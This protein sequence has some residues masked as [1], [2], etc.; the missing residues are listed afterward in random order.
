MLTRRTRIM[1]SKPP[2][3]SPMTARLLCLATIAALAGV[4]T[5][6]QESYDSPSGEVRITGEHFKRVVRVGDKS[7]PLDSVY[8]YASLR[9]KVGNL[10]LVSA[11]SGGNACA[12]D[13]RWLDTTPGKVAMSQSFG[14]CSDL[15]DVSNTPEVVTVTMPSMN[16]S[17]GKIAFDFDGKTISKRMLGLE[18]SG[19]AQGD[20]RAW[21]GKYT[22]DYLGAAENEARLIELMGWDML[23]V[24]RN[25]IL[26]TSE[27]FE[28]Q[29]GYLVAGGCKPHDC[30]DTYGA[31][32]LHI[33]TGEPLIAVKQDGANPELFGKPRGPLPNRIRQVMTGQ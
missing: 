28:E 29:D 15:V 24:A 4:P 8:A 9:E 2:R 17:E 14:T 19:V 13:F 16:V 11:S 12:A 30:A 20:T 31:V 21:A 27:V 22:A 6:A 3:F 1:D 7:F 5:L 33:E 18:S 10:I 26:V 32:A 25:A 23:A